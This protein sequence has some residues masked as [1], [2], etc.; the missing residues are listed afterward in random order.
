MMFWFCTDCRWLAGLRG[1]HQQGK[2]H[3]DDALA[4][5]ELEEGILKPPYAD[6]PLDRGHRLVPSRRRS[7]PPVMPA[8][9]AALIAGTI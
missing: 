8:A 4:E 7:R 3:D 5:A 2:D 1:C 9:K 6:H